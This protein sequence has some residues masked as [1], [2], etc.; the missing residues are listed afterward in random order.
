MRSVPVLAV[1]ALVAA[2]G[3]AADRV[4]APTPSGEA[5]ADLAGSPTV[6]VP[7]ILIGLDSNDDDGQPHRRTVGRLLLPRHTAVVHHPQ[8]RRRVEHPDRDLPH[9][10]LR[11]QRDGHGDGRPD[12]AH[13][14][15]E[16]RARTADGTVIARISAASDVRP[17]T[18]FI[19]IA[20]ATVYG[21]IPS[22]RIRVEVVAR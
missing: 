19:E 16:P 1:V 5:A 9:P 11:R 13:G 22:V 4:A 18:R 17:G 2:C 3:T 15:A 21:V 20:G 14:H 7:G 10:G 6:S 8:R 12:G